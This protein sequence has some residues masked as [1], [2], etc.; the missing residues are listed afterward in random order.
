MSASIATVTITS[1]ASLSSA[2][3]LQDYL[4]VGIQFPA[5][6]DAASITFQA[7]EKP[8]G[9]F[10]NVYDETGELTITTSAL[11]RHVVLGTTHRLSAQP[12][13]KIRSGTAGSP[14][15]QTA[16]RIITLVLQT[17]QP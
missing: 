7:A 13:I 17:L 12:A 5:G 11:S 16:D 9:T 6:W 8:A 2:I 15:N 14:V 4:L 3:G 10:N 1:G